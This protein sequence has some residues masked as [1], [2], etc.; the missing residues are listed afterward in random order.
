[1]DEHAQPAAGVATTQPDATTAA[2]TDAGNAATPQNAV[3]ASKLLSGYG[4]C[5]I[6]PKQVEEVFVRSQLNQ[7]VFTYF[8]EWCRDNRKLSSAFFKIPL[9]LDVGGAAEGKPERWQIKTIDTGRFINFKWRKVIFTAI[10]ALQSDKELFGLAIKVLETTA[11]PLMALLSRY[12]RSGLY[13][14]VLSV[15]VPFE[16]MHAFVVSQKRQN[17]I[18]S[19]RDAGEEGYEQDKA[20]QMTR[21][22]HERMRTL[23][24]RHGLGDELYRRFMMYLLNQRSQGMDSGADEPPMI[25]LHS[26]PDDKHMVVWFRDYDLLVPHFHHKIMTLGQPPEVECA[27]V[28][29][30]IVDHS[31]DQDRPQVMCENPKCDKTEGPSTD[32]T[33]MQTYEKHQGPRD[34]DETMWLKKRMA[35]IWR[36]K[37]QPAVDREVAEFAAAH[38]D[39]TEDDK[40]KK[41]EELIEKYEVDADKE[42]EVQRREI[43]AESRAKLN[44]CG[45][46]RAVAYCSVSCQKDDWARHKA[47]CTASSAKPATT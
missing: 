12:E 38:P 13:A 32:P 6:E 15:D 7:K 26:R 45:R 11:V 36:E 47:V 41:Q 4:Q 24:R 19:R 28:N 16:V 3:D 8:A 2:T 9:D 34:K 29:W 18:E 42:Q 10:P 27:F 17:E 1:M 22:E 23:W 20:A 35:I 43:V 39:A 46:C 14:S 33:I 25:M 37:Y 31:P 30:P 44:K 5:S 40:Q 21:E